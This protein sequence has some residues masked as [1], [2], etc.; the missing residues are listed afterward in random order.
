MNNNKPVLDQSEV[1][2]AYTDG[3]C[4]TQDRRGGWGFV[5][6]RGEKRLRRSGGELQTTSNR[7]ELTAAIKALEELQKRYPDNP[8]VVYSDSQYVVK[9]ITEWLENWKRN[10]WRNA[11]K[12]PVENA[13]LWQEL[14]TLNQALK[15]SWE[16]V[17]G[18]NGNPLNEEADK[19][20]YAAIPK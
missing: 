14:D 13:D 4:I 12:K 2:Y 8:V 10:G 7:M 6:A 18:H 11:S 5:L 3:A 15:V 17:K 16:W 9:G 1:N 20:A 19:L